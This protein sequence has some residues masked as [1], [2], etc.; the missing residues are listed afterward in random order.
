MNNLK[1]NIQN[2]S[3]FMH[4]GKMN[5]YLNLLNDTVKLPHENPAIGIIL[6][7]DKDSLEVEYAI[8]NTNQ[9]LGVSTYTIEEKL[10]LELEKLLPSSEEITEILL[11]LD[12]KEER[13]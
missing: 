10:P 4:A 2:S 12:E 3:L 9:P 11:S 7:S 13:K 5:F 8:Q 6:C 1:L